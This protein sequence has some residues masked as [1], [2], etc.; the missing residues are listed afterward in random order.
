[1]SDPT[2]AVVTRVSV[3]LRGDAADKL[4]AVAARHGRSVEEQAAISLTA[5]LAI[6][7]TGRTLTIDSATIEALGQILGGGSVLNQQDLLFK[8]QRLA[9]ISFRH[10]RLPFTP[11]QLEQL[12]ERADRQGLTVQQLVERTAPRMYEQFFN[13]LPT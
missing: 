2:Q 1:M 4:E 11:N 5:G 6:P 8:V 13:M 7:S 9:G 3:L 12:Q 10:V